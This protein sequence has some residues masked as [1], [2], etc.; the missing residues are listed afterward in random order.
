MNIYE[1][2]SSVLGNGR[3]NGNE[4]QFRCPV[5]DKGGAGHFYVNLSTGQFYCHKCGESGG[6]KKFRDTYNI[7]VPKIDTSECISNYVPAIAAKCYAYLIAKLTLT[8]GDEKF[9]SE[10]RG[11]ENIRSYGLK[12]MTSSDFLLNKFSEYELIASGLFKKVDDKLIRAGV[13][14]SGRILIP[15]IKKGK[16]EFIRSRAGRLGGV[17]YFSPVGS[18]SGNRYY[19]EIL[20]KEILITEGEFKAIAATQAGY[21]AIGLPGMNSSHKKIAED[22]QHLGVKKAIICFDAQKDMTYVQKAE[23]RLASFLSLMGV[24]SRIVRLPLRDE[25]KMD[26]DSF[27]YKYGRKELR[28]VIND[29]I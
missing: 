17:K 9:I 18:D 3:I 24:S 2:F 27:V 29:A 28:R 21:N 26:I 13:I 22:C 15:Y 7:D 1:L 20:S 12:S 16:V 5:C 25:E 14:E 19:G 23:E 10:G 11:I 6:I 8:K 4:A